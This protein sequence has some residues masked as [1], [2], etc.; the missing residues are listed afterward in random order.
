[1]NAL[2][3]YKRDV[4][5]QAGENG[6]IEEIF[7]R[8]ESRTRWCVEF[9]AWDGERYSNT[10]NLVN[11][12]GW[13]G[14]YIESNK[15]RFARLQEKYAHNPQVVCIRACVSHGEEPR[16]LDKILSAVP[17]LPTEFDLLSIDVDGNDYHI[18]A[19][20]KQYVPR[21]VLIENNPTIPP[22]M[23]VVG[24]PGNCDLGCSARALVKLG[25]EKGYELVAHTGPNCIFAHESDFQKIGISDNSLERLFSPDHLRYLIS[26]FDGRAFV[27][28]VPAYGYRPLT[29][30]AGLRRLC[31][32]IINAAM[33]IRWSTMGAI[34]DCLKAGTNP[35]RV[36]RGVMFVCDDGRRR[37][38]EPPR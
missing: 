26:T 23:D 31:R 2:S 10:W 17:Q 21:V 8:I 16:T 27:P 5:S 15:R 36:C 32:R 13:H 20:V 14:V 28:K 38:D 24:P 4:T 7:S 12:N 34:T 11:R 33:G 29:P 35:G 19:G 22:H 9:G 6:I 18:W 25:K 1:M 30:G 37:A 3:A